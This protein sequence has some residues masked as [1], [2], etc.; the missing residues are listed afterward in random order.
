MSYKYW[1]IELYHCFSWLFLMEP[2]SNYR[3]ISFLYSDLWTAFT[4][5]IMFSGNFSLLCY[6]RFSMFKSL[7]VHTQHKTYFMSPSSIPINKLNSMTSNIKL[8]NSKVSSRIQ[9]VIL[10]TCISIFI[11]GG[12]TYNF[13]VYY[14]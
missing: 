14:T 10:Q 5:T 8:G 11:V 1:S 12:I 13:A 9:T 3:C 2:F 7:L 6:Q 4:A